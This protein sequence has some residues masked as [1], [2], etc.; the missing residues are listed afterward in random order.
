MVWNV[1]ERALGVP[2]ERAGALIDGLGGSTDRLWPAPPWPAMRLD[3]PVAVGAPG[4]P[5]AIRYAV[6]AHEPRRRVEFVLDPRAGADG[7]HTFTV[8]PMGDDWCLLRHEMR[9]R[10]TGRLR[11]AWPLAVRWM[12]DAL[13]EDLLDRAQDAVGD[14]PARRNRHSGW[15]RVLRWLWT[16][17]P[18]AGRAGGSR[19][20]RA[21]PR[22]A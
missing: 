8:R 19:P 14:P 20:L 16:S 3:R 15:V 17:R 2:A 9:I 10:L 21:V 18:Q 7:T 13:L 6:A 22:Q 1:H 11:L 5:R 12:H 4:G